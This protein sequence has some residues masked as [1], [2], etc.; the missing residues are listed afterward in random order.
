[1][2]LQAAWA[3]IKQKG[4]YFGAQFR[5]I[6]RRRG[7]KCAALAVAHSLLTVIYHLL[8]RGVVYEDLGAD[9]FDRRSPEQHACYHLRRLAELG[10]QVSLDPIEAA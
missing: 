2:L 1:V 8:T 5:R 10:Y 4:S 9:Y 7:E 3:A 6:A